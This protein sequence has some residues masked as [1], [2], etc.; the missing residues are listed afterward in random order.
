[1]TILS[2]GIERFQQRN[3]LVPIQGLLQNH[4]LAV[5]PTISEDGTVQIKLLEECTELSTK[6][7]LLKP[8]LDRYPASKGISDNWCRVRDAKV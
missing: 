3:P 2:K 5:R 4:I 1:M 6:N 7:L 8:S